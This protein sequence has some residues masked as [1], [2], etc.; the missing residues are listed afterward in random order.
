MSASFDIPFDN[1]VLTS[2][3]GSHQAEFQLQRKVIQPG[4]S[5]LSTRRGASGPQYPPFLAISN[6]NTDDF[7]GK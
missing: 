5:I 4:R 2:F 7:S 3:S 1:Q 6:A